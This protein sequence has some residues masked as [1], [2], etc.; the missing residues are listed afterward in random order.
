MRILLEL[1]SDVAADLLGRGVRGDEVRV[2][3]FERFEFLHEHVE[4]VVAYYGGV[5]LVISSAV[6]RDCFAEFR[7]AYF[8]LFMFHVKKRNNLQN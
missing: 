4:L 8:C 2:F 7:Y 5:F 6:L 1:L 3:P